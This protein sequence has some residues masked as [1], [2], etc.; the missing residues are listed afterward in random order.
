[1]NSQLFANENIIVETIPSFEERCGSW[2]ESGLLASLYRKG[3]TPNKCFTELLANSNDAQ[4]TQF[5]WKITWQY[6]KLVDDGIGMN[7]KKLT[8]GNTS[9]VVKHVYDYVNK[10]RINEESR[11]EK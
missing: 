6:I 9:M 7:Y 5:L 1:M 8:E 2:D 11:Y 4:S 3:F 10:K